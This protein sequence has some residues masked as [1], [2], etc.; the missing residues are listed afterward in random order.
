MEKH[1]GC[2]YMGII[3]SQRVGDETK[4][5]LEEDE[6]AS[7]RR[8]G[9]E[10]DPMLGRLKV[11]AREPLEQVA[12]DDDERVAHAADGSPAAGAGA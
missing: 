2:A 9:I 7:R 1:G 10:S 3:S 8:F 11:S 6:R 12:A 4:C 5:T